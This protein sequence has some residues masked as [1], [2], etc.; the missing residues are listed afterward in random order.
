MDIQ[1]SPLLPAERGE[2][3]VN[4]LS[5]IF[6]SF[7]SCIFYFIFCFQQLGFYRLPRHGGGLEGGFDFGYS[8][9]IVPLI[10][11]IS[12]QYFLKRHQRFCLRVRSLRRMRGGADEG[13]DCLNF[14][15]IGQ[16]ITCNSY[17][18]PDCFNRLQHIIP[19]SQS[20][21]VGW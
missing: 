19:P 4:M 8:R 3:F 5:G 18:V 1:S 20:A 17:E 13:F 11:K 15:V 16:A 2:G 10:P 21:R 12:V 6:K 7:R 9:F 14:S